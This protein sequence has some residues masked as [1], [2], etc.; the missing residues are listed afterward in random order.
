MTDAPSKCETTPAARPGAA[1]AA[2]LRRVGW[3]VVALALAVGSFS[4]MRRAWQGRPDWGDLQT[5]SRYVWEHSYTAPGTAMFGYLPTTTFALWPFM[6]WTGWPL[7]AGLFVLSNVVAG[8]GT[9]LIVRRWWIGTASPTGSFV[10][11]VLLVSVNFA[12]AIQANQTTMW[13]LLLCVGGLT[14]VER[15]RGLT[16]GLV[17][18]LAALVKT[19]PVLLAGYLLLRRRW[20]ALAGMAAAFMVF[21][22]LPS[23]VF[24]GWS[25][26]VVEHR[27]WLRRAEW[28]SN[29]RQIEEPLLRVHRHGHNSSYSAVL[30]RWLRPIP[31][32]SRQV[33]LYGQPSA[34]VV[35][36]RRAALAPDEILTLDPMPPRAGTAFEKHVDIGWVPRFHIGELQAGVVWWIWAGTL[37]AGLLVLT[38]ATWST[39]R[40]A[41]VWPAVAALWMLAMFW[42][43]P[44]ARHYYLA[45]AFPAIAVVWSALAQHVQV[46]VR[47]RGAGTRLAVA[48]LAAW[49]V[50][51][52]CLGWHLARWYGIHLAVLALLMAA[53][54]WAWRCTFR[55]TGP[56][57]REVVR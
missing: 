16:G 6:V 49:G 37:A 9:I 25:G 45:W 8:V 50:G 17:L 15:R 11:P 4:A 41:Q 36:A 54:A 13:T 44:M 38:W 5:E 40:S 10:W 34:D 30:A 12:H 55:N 19:V 23:V 14:L 57:S 29:R 21:D 47:H 27:A 51:L 26:A 2:L 32:A 28:H 46:P 1:R 53:T 31:T 43:S 48:A 35:A 39:G 33:I 7:G 42:P 52:A 24:F 3:F 56:P 20:L 18:G 22:A